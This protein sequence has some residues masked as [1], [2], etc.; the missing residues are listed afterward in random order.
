MKDH[1][2]HMQGQD[3]NLLLEDTFQDQ[4][5]ELQKLEHLHPF[6]IQA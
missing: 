1:T 4:P 2:L 5:L 3:H 6:Q